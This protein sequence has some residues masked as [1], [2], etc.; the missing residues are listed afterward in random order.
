[1]GFSGRKDGQN[2]RLER[3]AGEVLEAFKASEAEINAVAASRDL[4]K[5]VQARIAAE[6]ERR[7]EVSFIAT[8]PSPFAATR[9]SWRAWFGLHPM[10][11]SLAAA[12]VGLL[13]LIAVTVPRWVS[14]SHFESAKVALAEKTPAP[15]PTVAST[16]NAPTPGPAAAES[17]RDGSEA[18][19]PEIGSEHSQPTK[20]RRPVRQ[21]VAE[22]DESEEVATNYLPLTPTADAEGMSGQV[23]RIQLPR[24]ALAQFG[25]AVS[26]ERADELVKADVVLGDDGLARAI[27]LIQQR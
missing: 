9:F 24:S 10:G 7:E 11:W 12:A 27:R 3:V 26:P 15:A 23:V 13:L 18:G 25:V 19:Q 21:R 4:F 14:N 8:S 22:P 6:Q 16:P 2:E 5:R 1:M 20:P 17:P